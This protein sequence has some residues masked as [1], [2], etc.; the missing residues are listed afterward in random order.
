MIV[1]HM[2]SK[3]FMKDTGPDAVESRDTILERLGRI[4]E[5]SYPI[6]PP[7]FIVSDA[8]LTASMM[9]SKESSIIGETKQL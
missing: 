4:L 1:A 2:A 5:K 8:D 3:I 7:L 9:E 6:P